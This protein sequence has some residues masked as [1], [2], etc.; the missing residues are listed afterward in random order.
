MSYRNEGHV[1]CDE[2][3][4]RHTQLVI[5]EIDFLNPWHEEQSLMVTVDKKKKFRDAAGGVGHR[6]GRV[7]GFEG[8]V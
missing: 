8:V 3:S 7:T 6:S 1:E 5:V 4:Y 2:K